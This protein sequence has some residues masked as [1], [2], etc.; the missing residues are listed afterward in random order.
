MFNKITFL[1]ALMTIGLNSCQDSG[2][3]R[4]S[5]VVSDNVSVSI[6]DT[7]YVDTSYCRLPIDIL[8]IPG[9]KRKVIHVNKDSILISLVE[10]NF[11]TEKSCTD[12]KIGAKIYMYKSSDFDFSDFIWK[13]RQFEQSAEVD[14]DAF[15]VFRGYDAYK[16]KKVIKIYFRSGAFLTAYYFDNGMILTKNELIIGAL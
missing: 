16:R 2:S 10:S 1:I 13:S 7:V 3:D 4:P 15:I 5:F 8:E 14:L 6:P 11:N 9:V 12:F